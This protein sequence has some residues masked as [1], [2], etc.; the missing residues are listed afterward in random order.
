MMQAT[1][2]MILGSTH[3]GREEPR[4][5]DDALAG[6]VDRIVRW[7]PDAIAIE[8][9]PGE[10]ID[11]YLRLGG[12]WAGMRVGGL[13]QAEACAGVVQGAHTDLWEAR[14]IGGDPRRPLADRVVAW[15]AAYEPY[16]ALLL[17]RNAGDLGAEVGGALEAVA[18]LGDERVRIAAA[19]AARLGLERLHP[20]DDHGDGSLFGDIAED[21]YDAFIRALHATATAHPLVAGQHAAMAR[22]RES[23]DLWP[24]LR[25]LNSAQTVADSD[26]LESGYF[27][28][29]G[30][31]QQM[32]RRA[33]AAWRTRNLLM[34]ARLRAVTGE[35]PGGRVLALVGQAHKGP[36]EGALGVGQWDLEIA[37]VDEL[38]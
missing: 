13:P 26:E 22:V 18:A 5:A 2:L 8:V 35:H 10:L 21:E 15:C 9:L 31:P 24:M 29:H 1:R 7:R 23:G 37:S 14:R 16:T 38:E 32:A 36:L 30:R 4:L 19:A 12:P 3:L 6:V 20:F 27:L 11:S 17:A 28:E 34:A 25:E 33:L